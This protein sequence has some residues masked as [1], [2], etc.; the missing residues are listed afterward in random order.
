MCA[1]WPQDYAVA[2]DK[3]FKKIVT[4]GTT[5]TDKNVDFTVKVPALHAVISTACLCNVTEMRGSSASA[6]WSSSHA[7]HDLARRRWRRAA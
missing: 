7:P 5:I 6:A 4:R 1:P 3:Q 2:T